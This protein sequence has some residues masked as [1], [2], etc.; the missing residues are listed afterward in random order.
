[1]K[2]YVL[3]GV[4][5]LRYEEIDRPAVPENWAL[6]RVKAAGICSSDVPRICKTGTYHFPTVPGHEFCGEVAAVGSGSDVALVGKRVGVFPLIPCKKCESCRQKKYETCQ[7][8]DYLGSRRD[9]GFAEYV[10]CPVWNLIELPDAVSYTQ[11]AVLE[12]LAV[13]RHALNAA[14]LS[15]VKTAAIIGTGAIGLFMAM[16]LRSEGKEVTLVGRSEGKRAL[17]TRCGIGDYIVGDD[18]RKFDLTVEAVGSSAS[19]AQSVALARSGGQVV[20]VGNPA[21]ETMSLDKAVYWQIL[22]R[23]LRVYGTWNS[24]YE[25]DAPSDWSEVLRLVS[26]GKV[27][28]EKAI[29]HVLSQERLY[30]GLEIMKNKTA[31]YGRIVVKFNE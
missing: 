6:V 8:Y 15:D 4:N 1:M 24:S 9:G 14:V 10:A 18:G 5:D 28:P 19:L 21:D 30:D 3:H 7:N 2:A 16:I 31:V 22:R 29:T 12:P 13:A 26:E 25:K 20:L 27:D 17:A 23:Q 11:A